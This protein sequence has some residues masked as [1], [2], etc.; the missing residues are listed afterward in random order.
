MKR[1]RLA[2][3][4]GAHQNFFGVF[5][6]DDVGEIAEVGGANLSDVKQGVD[7][8]SCEAVE[9]DGL[10]HFLADQRSHLAE[11]LNKKIR[12]IENKNNISNLNKRLRPSRFIRLSVVVVV[13]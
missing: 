7:A 9:K 13:F 4:K 11:E 8:E 2:A 5:T 3:F 1:H 6:A 12:L 10:G